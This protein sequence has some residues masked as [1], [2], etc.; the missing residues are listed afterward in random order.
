MFELIKCALMIGGYF[1]IFAGFGYL[2]SH[3]MKLETTLTEK[4][5]FGFFCYFSLFQL[6][7]LPLIMLKQTL[8]LLTVLWSIILGIVAVIMIFLLYKERIQI[9]EV[10]S[11]QK[12]V[13]YFTGKNLLYFV[14]VGI[15]LGFLCYF[16]AIQN[17]WGWDTAF[18]IGT[19]STSLDTD[20]MYLYNG[21]NGVLRKKISFRYALSA[22]YMNSAV[23]CKITGISAVMFQKYVMGILCAILHT[24]SLGFI[25]KKLYGKN[26]EKVVLFIIL[27]GMLNFFFVSGFST[28]NF[29]LFRSYEAKAY[30]ANV[31][32]TAVFGAILGVHQNLEKKENWKVLFLIMMASVP[33]SMS[34]ILIVPMIV[35]VALA[36]EYIMTK[37]RKIIKYGILCMIPNGIYLVIYLLNTLK[38]LEIRV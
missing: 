37:N 8:T 26:P 30:C 7:A 20:T 6:V 28:S 34:S 10:L 4:V 16:V 24:I 29:L 18:Y 9:K 1:V 3:F 13:G 36:A 22:F 31:V 25:G 5:L 21:E 15:F 19:V 33:V 32:I 2:V 27:A 35:F 23:F 17:F 12:K 14:L 38:V 11:K